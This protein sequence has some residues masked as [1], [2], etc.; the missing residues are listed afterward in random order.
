MSPKR[1]V[2]VAVAFEIQKHKAVFGQAHVLGAGAPVAEPQRVKPSQRAGR[3]Q[4]KRPPTHGIILEMQQMTQIRAAIRQNDVIGALGTQVRHGGAGG[5]HFAKRDTFTLERGPRIALLQ[6]ETPVQP[7]WPLDPERAAANLYPLDARCR[8]APVRLGQHPQLFFDTRGRS[9]IHS[10]ECMYLGWR[11]KV[12]TS[13]L[14]DT[15]LLSSIPRRK[16]ETRHRNP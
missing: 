7:L 6:T 5:I 14:R 1:V 4:Q 3:I 2:A 9:V 16:I 15:S 10:G 8:A 11:R 12:V 13:S